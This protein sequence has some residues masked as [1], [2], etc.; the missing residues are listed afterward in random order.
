MAGCAGWGWLA[1]ERSDS[2]GS[3]SLSCWGV[4][5]CG[6]LR[7]EWIA[8]ERKR[9]SVA[10]RGWKPEGMPIFPSVSDVHLVLRS[11]AP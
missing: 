1:C 4:G 2:R 10:V 11:R 7:V 6:A 5:V 9:E 3:R 8:V